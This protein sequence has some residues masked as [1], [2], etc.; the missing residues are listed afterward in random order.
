MK[1]LLALCMLMLPVLNCQPTIMSQPPRTGE[2]P[3]RVGS[4]SMST[5]G[6]D[7]NVDWAC[8]QTDYTDNLV[9]IECKFEN[10]SFH[11]K[12]EC[13]RVII[14]AASGKEVERSR[15]VCT[16]MMKPGETYE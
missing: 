5:I 16:N 8:R 11:T 10:R 6:F 7:D 14:S 12:R 2:E 13:I 1:K 3:M 4:Q 9:W 15:V